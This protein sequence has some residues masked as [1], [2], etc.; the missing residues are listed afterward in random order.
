MR[1]LPFAPVGPV[2]SA[3]QL[4]WH[5]RG[6]TAFFHFGINT[7][8]DKEWGDPKSYHLMLNTSALGYEGAARAIIAVMEDRA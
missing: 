7:F 6:A 3:R 4:D 1:P 8:T 2:P 5:G